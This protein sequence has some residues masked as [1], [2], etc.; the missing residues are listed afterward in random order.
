MLF[1]D[2]LSLNLLWTSCHTSTFT[3]SSPPDTVIGS[4]VT[5]SSCIVN[6]LSWL[7]GGK[8]SFPLRGNYSHPADRWHI[9]VTLR[10]DRRRPSPWGYH[11]RRREEVIMGGNRGAY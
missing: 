8:F 6:P 10:C 1:L 2:S 7:K 5:A 4:I 11:W 9:T 3:I